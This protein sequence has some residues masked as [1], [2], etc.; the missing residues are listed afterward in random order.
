[1]GSRVAHGPTRS[2]PGMPARLL[3]CYSWLPQESVRAPI[4][5]RSR[6]HA[7][8]AARRCVRAGFGR[9]ETVTDATVARETGLATD[10]ATGLAQLRA[11]PGLSRRQSGDSSRIGIV[12]ADKSS[13]AETTRARGARPPFRHAIGLLTRPRRGTCVAEK[14]AFAN[15]SATRAEQSGTIGD[16]PFAFASRRR[17]RGRRRAGGCQRRCRGKRAHNEPDGKCGTPH[18]VTIA[19]S[20]PRSAAPC[21]S[22]PRRR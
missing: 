9:K 19:L 21:S 1:V 15:G 20:L 14:T 17:R 5:A 18:V 8:L 12:S 4:T 11:I 22:S 3:A 10:R 16:A 6:V 13:D 7:P 2:L